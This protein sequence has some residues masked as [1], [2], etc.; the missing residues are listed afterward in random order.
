[1][2]HCFSVSHFSVCS[3]S[4]NYRPWPVCTILLPRTAAP[5][6]FLTSFCSIILP[7][8]HFTPHSNHV[9]LLTLFSLLFLLLFIILSN[10]AYSSLTLSLSLN[11]SRAGKSCDFSEAE[12]YKTAVLGGFSVYTAPGLAL[13]LRCCSLLGAHTADP[14]FPPFRIKCDPSHFKKK[15]QRKGVLSVC[16]RARIPPFQGKE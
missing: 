5:T 11:T 3:C 15:K 10:I 6:F 12:P 7:D 1:M 4:C 13:V 14:L 8:L 16:V 9:T 2:P